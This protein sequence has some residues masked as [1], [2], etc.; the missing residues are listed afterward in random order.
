[1][2]GNGAEGHQKNILSLNVD[3]C[4]ELF[5]WLTLS[6]LK[7]LRLTCTRLKTIVNHFIKS[8]YTEGFGML[9]VFDKYGSKD[10]RSFDST[11]NQ[12]YKHVCLYG[13]ISDEVIE[14]IKPILSKIE[15][16]SIHNVNVEV[17][18]SKDFL[19]LCTHLMH[20]HI[21]CTNPSLDN[22]WMLHQFPSLKH[23][24]LMRY[25]KDE[26]TTQKLRTFFELNPNV[27]Q[28]TIYEDTVMMN[29]HWMSES[30]V[31]F[32]D[33]N[34]LCNNK[35]DMSTIYDVLKDQ[36]KGGFY[37]RLNLY[38][39]YKIDQ[40]DFNSIAALDGLN[41]LYLDYMGDV[42]M[43]TTPM[44]QL[45]ELFLPYSPTSVNESSIL[46]DSFM[47]IERLFVRKGYLKSIVP[48][49]CCSAKLKV[50][51]IQCFCVE[52][53]D[54]YWNSLKFIDLPALNRER[55]KCANASKI[56]IY[57]NEYMYLN[58]KKKTVQRKIRQTVEG[59]AGI[60]D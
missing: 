33:L 5:A 48:F 16:V 35:G 40:D 4:E 23:L 25:S 31:H 51:E 52:S 10:L 29:S 27:R 18:F 28:F 39:R 36:F 56:K 14:K 34:I 22:E 44:P 42:R 49:I 15:K 50:I 60:F 9:E 57:V 43:R 19:Q 3:C 55:E 41:T 12:V 2:S 24:N 1:M 59:V 47:N 54:N 46:I 11:F 13:T 38:F 20:L 7:M 45:K 58:M 32:D 30:N 6:D 8:N 21:D 53:R 37:K 17:D 26:F